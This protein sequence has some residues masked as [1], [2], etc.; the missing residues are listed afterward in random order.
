MARSSKG[1]SAFFLFALACAPAA[2]P[3]AVTPLR[4]SP[5]QA[6]DRVRVSHHSLCCTTPSIGLASAITTD[7]VV[8]SPET[9]SHSFAIPRAD[10]N[11][12]DRWDRGQT[13]RT[14][15]AFL[16]MFGGAAAGAAVGS[17]TACKCELRSLDVLGGAVAGGMV[18]ILAGTVV[19]SIHHG[20]WKPA[21]FA[22]P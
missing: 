21:R 19:G 12:V 18:G 6:G 10:I 3:T 5:V 16:G 20:A 4:V 2:P 14:A 1:A 11:A 13:H 15:G 8:L 22:S 7:S 17:L 9:G